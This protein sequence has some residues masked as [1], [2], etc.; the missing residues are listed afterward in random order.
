MSDLTNG[1]TGLAIG[2]NKGH[3]CASTKKVWRSRPVLK[4]GKI[5]KRVQHV[6]EVIREVAGFSNLEKKMIE[7]IRTGVASKEKKAVKTARAK[8]GTHR[9]AILKRDAIGKIIQQQ[10]RK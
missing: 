8:L 1:R 9:R 7:L 3:A 6:R 5:T 2:P 4:K 10:R